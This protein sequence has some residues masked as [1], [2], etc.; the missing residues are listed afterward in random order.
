MVPTVSPR[1]TTC[2]LLLLPIRVP[3]C[4]APGYASLHDACRVPRMPEAPARL[5]KGSTLRSTPGGS[6]GKLRPADIDRARHDFCRYLDN[7][8]GEVLINTVSTLE[9]VTKHLASATNSSDV[10]TGHGAGKC[11]EVLSP[12]ERKQ[13]RDL[14]V[15]S[16]IEHSTVC[17]RARSRS[18]WEIRRR[19]ARRRAN[20]D[21]TRQA[22]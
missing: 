11:A 8:G 1:L 15:L 7:G 13:L 3:P 10:F 18:I 12:G 22:C 2:L 17:W 6:D 14:S 16:S 9:H 4:R 21:L 19:A 20:L 5:P